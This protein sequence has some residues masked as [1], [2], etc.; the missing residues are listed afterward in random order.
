[1]YMTKNQNQ[2]VTAEE[3]IRLKQYLSIQS[4]DFCRNLMQELN[5]ERDPQVFSLNSKWQQLV[6]LSIAFEA[7]RIQGIREERARHGKKGR[8]PANGSDPDGV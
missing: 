3:V 8:F 5:K 1:M 6:F 7:G 4:I 2:Y